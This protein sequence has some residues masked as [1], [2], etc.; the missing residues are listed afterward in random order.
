MIS[1]AWRAPVQGDMTFV[2]NCWIMS[3]RLIILAYSRLMETAK[4]GTWLSLERRVSFNHK[5]QHEQRQLVETV[6]LWL[7]DC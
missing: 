1:Q 6:F 2:L 3:S 5:P 4:T 7:A